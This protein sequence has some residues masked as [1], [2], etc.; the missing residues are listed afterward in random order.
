MQKNL[1]NARNIMDSSNISFEI[2]EQVLSSLKRLGYSK[3]LEGIRPLTIEGKVV[4]DADMCDALGING[5]LRIYKY[6][7]K[8]NKPFFD[9]NVFPA[10]NVDAALYKKKCAESSVCHIFEKI[11]K[12]K[13][14][15]M[16][17]SGKKEAIE[18]HQIIVDVLYQLF[19]EEKTDDWKV[20]LDNF[21]SEEYCVEE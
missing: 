13:K 12:L 14:L 15:M 6:S 7:F 10:G 4:S 11:L 8:N 17:E 1:T 2:Q 20:Y 3:S 18:R 9:K 16:T 5:L 21:L 19:K